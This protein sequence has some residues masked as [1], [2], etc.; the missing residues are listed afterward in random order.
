MIPIVDVWQ[1]IKRVMTK[2]PA[3]VILQKVTNEAFSEQ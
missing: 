1:M 3:S 2:D